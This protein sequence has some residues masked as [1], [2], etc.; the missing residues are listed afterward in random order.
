MNE[1]DMILELTGLLKDIIYNEDVSIYQSAIEGNHNTDFEK[2]EEKARAAISR[3]DMMGSEI[4]R[5]E[6]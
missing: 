1:N 2:W 4:R 5:I 6:P 3:A